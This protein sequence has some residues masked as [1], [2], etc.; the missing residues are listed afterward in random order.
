MLKNLSLW[1]FY[2]LHMIWW[3]RSFASLSEVISTCV[4]S[5]FKIRKVGFS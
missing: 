4:K 5:H 3:V 2:K 1:C